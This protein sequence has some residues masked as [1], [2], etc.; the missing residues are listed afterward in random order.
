MKGFLFLIF[1][2]L[3]IFGD[4]KFNAYANLI[5]FLLMII[6]SHRI[7]SDCILISIAIIITIISIFLQNPI[8]FYAQF[9]ISLTV[10]TFQF[11]IRML[12][13]SKLVFIE[14]KNLSLTMLFV[15]IFAAYLTT[16]YYK[17]NI[18][19]VAYFSTFGR[20]ILTLV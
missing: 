5:L 11:S 8:L 3:A 7:K 19:A 20:S 17:D 15:T 1:I 12:R 16:S 6:I 13:E 9:L 18:K 14:I 2:F 4:S 10:L